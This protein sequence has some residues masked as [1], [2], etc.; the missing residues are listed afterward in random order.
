MRALMY[1]E[2]GRVRVRS[3]GGLD[4]A[5]PL[6]ELRELGGAVRAERA[7][8]DGEIVAFGPDGRVSFSALQER[9]YVHRPV[10]V[11]ELTAGSQRR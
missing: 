2:G 9:M 11:A 6:P 3:R 8:L 1:I 5:G 10:R 4:I 7:V